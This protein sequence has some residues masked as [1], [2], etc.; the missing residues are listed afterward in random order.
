ML[1]V[2]VHA[3]RVGQVLHVMLAPRVQLRMIAAVMHQPCPE[4]D[5]GALALVYLLTSLAIAA[6]QSTR[7]PPRTATTTEL[8]PLTPN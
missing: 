1:R 5:L 2:S 8:L 7:A 3:M 4:I 6:Y